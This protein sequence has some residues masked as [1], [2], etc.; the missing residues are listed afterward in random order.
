[1]TAFRHH[2]RCAAA[3]ALVGPAVAL[4]QAVE[5]ALTPPPSDPLLASLVEE[6]L[7]ARPELRRAAAVAAAERERIPQAGALPDPVLSLGIQNDG[8]EAITIGEMPM[9][10]WQVML[11]QGVP[12]PGKRGLRTE[13]ARLFASQAEAAVARARLG[14]EADVRRAYLDLLL[15]RDRLRLLGTLEAIWTQSAGLARARYEAGEGAQSDVLRAQLEL[16]RLRQ[17]R[18]ALGAAERTSLQALNRLRARPLDEPIVTRAGLHDLEAPALDGL[19][20]ATADAERRSPELAQARLGVSRAAASAELARRERFPDLAVTAAIMPRGP[21]DPMWQAGLSV[22][23]P[24]W[25]GRKQGRAVAESAARAEAESRGA[26][27]LEQVLRLRVAERQAELAS[28]LE[29]VRLYRGGLLVQS[30]AT[31]ESTLAQYRVGRVTFASV[32]EANAGL[33]ADEEGYLSTLAD[34]HR[35]AI[36]AHEVSLERVSRGGGAGMGPS[37][38][39]GA[40]AVGSPASMKASGGAPAA[41]PTSTPP[42]PGGM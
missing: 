17:R 2:L 37:S 32:L 22:G 28:L 41:S 23:L 4:A 42:M 13:V 19:A 25:A 33:L 36:A 3:L 34:A 9:S 18:A 16:N 10:Y 11:T 35:V 8:L 30:K 39:P 1:M 5:P 7:A 24:L 20:A 12:W 31:V 38:L 14:T 6:S 27:G 26:E 21:L 29:T 15:A 40:G